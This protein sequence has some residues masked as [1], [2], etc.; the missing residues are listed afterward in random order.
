M[1]KTIDSRSCLTV[2]L[3]V[4]YPQKSLDGRM[5]FK[6]QVWLGFSPCYILGSDLPHRLLSQCS[7]K[8]HSSTSQ[9]KPGPH[10][11]LEPFL[12]LNKAAVPTLMLA[13]LSLVKF[14]H[15][16]PSA[17]QGLQAVGLQ[18]ALLCAS[19]LSLS[20]IQCTPRS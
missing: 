15:Q 20:L 11:L 18:K 5:C 10:Q 19:L 4:S 12:D 2:W 9:S 8:L 1:F 3:E 17:A 6:L 14:N 16:L 7:W 13:R